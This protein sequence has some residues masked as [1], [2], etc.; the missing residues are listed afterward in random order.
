V[1]VTIESQNTGKGHGRWVIVVAAPVVV[2]LGLGSSL[3][4]LGDG[5]QSLN[6]GVLANF[7]QIAHGVVGVA[8]SILAGVGAFEVRR[9][10]RRVAMIIV[11]GLVVAWLSWLG[12]N[13]LAI[14]Q[15]RGASYTGTA[16]I[17][18]GSAVL[19]SVSVACASVVGDD[20]Q[21]AEVDVQTNGFDLIVR[22]RTDRTPEPMI[23]G[24]VVVGGSSVTFGQV[25]SI[26]ANELVG[27]A[28]VSAV[29]VGP[30]GGTGSPAEVAIDWTCN[31]GSRVPIT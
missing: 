20:T 27:H 6:G 11:A 7:W 24:T 9:R 28:T 30:A 1:Q 22:H 19:G 18:L 5:R 4:G 31:L 29:V 13:V 14:T 23:S 12:G 21:I 26:V 3:V 2:L 15:G 10:S 25:E 16:Q 8:L 17:S